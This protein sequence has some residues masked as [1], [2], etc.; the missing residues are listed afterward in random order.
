MNRCGQQWAWEASR[1]ACREAM[2]RNGS[3]DEAN[4]TIEGR[5]RGRAGLGEEGGQEGMGT[6]P[7]NLKWRKT[8]L[9]L[10]EIALILLAVS[11]LWL[12]LEAYGLGLE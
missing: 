6:K 12:G 2:E 4:R 11:E 9:V 10:S 7:K 5:G 3:R 8:K 1:G